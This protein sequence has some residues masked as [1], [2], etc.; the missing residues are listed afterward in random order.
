MWRSAIFV[1]LAP[2]LLW[3]AG[4]GESLYR[5]HCAPCHGPRG[6]GGRGPALAVRSL[7][8]APDDAALAGIITAGIPGTQMPPTR[9]TAEENRELRE[10]VRS[11]GRA[12]PEMAPGDAT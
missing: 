3:S 9:M 12:A 4:S 1:T 5:T 10:Y 6:E 11:L 2:A 8:R 7:P